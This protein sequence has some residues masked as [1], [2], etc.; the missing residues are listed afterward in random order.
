[1]HIRYAMYIIV[2]FYIPDKPCTRLKERAKRVVQPLARFTFVLAVFSVLS[3]LSASLFVEAVMKFVSRWRWL[4]AGLSA[5]LVLMVLCVD[6]GHRHRLV[7][8]LPKIVANYDT[9]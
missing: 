4:Q 7:I 8:D 1:M 3:C 5:L 9:L 6:N 2:M